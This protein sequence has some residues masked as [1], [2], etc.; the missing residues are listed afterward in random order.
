MFS[1][2]SSCNSSTMQSLCHADPVSHVSRYLL[3]SWQAPST[4]GTAVLAS[5]N[6]KWWVIPTKS[7]D[8]LISVPSSVKTKQPY[9]TSYFVM[10]LIFCWFWIFFF[11]IKIS[12][13]LIP[14]VM[15]E[16]LTA[17]LVQGAWKIRIYIS[18]PYN[19]IRKNMKPSTNFTLPLSQHS[20]P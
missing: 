19:L 17:L 7:A 13:F 12:S 11:L 20:G 14:S 2:S 15:V 16:E 5:H 4:S 10:I 9:S 18:L 8:T 6:K 1:F 3:L